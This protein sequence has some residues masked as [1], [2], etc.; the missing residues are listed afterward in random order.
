MSRCTGVALV[1]L[2]LTPPAA[3]LASLAGSY[4]ID[5]FA[6]TAAQSAGAVPPGAG[7]LT[8]VIVLNAVLLAATVLAGFLAHRMARSRRDQHPAIGF[9]GTTTLV[10]AVVFGAGIIFIAL[11]GIALGGCS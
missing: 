4:A 7:V 1:V 8:A 11:V 9:L 3:W 2:A 6:C 10:S 5:D